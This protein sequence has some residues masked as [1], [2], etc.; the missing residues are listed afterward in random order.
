[1]GIHRHLPWRGTGGAE[2]LEKTLGCPAA[3][4]CF[5]GLTSFLKGN[6]VIYQ[7][8]KPF[9][10][11]T[12]SF[13]STDWRAVVGSEMSIIEW[14]LNRLKENTVERKPQHLHWKVK[15]THWRPE[16]QV[17]TRSESPRDLWGPVQVSPPAWRLCC[18]L[19][20]CYFRT[21]I[22]STH[23]PLGPWV[24]LSCT[25]FSLCIHTAYLPLPDL[26]YGYV[27]SASCWRII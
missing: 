27:S 26:C 13:N 25:F 21:Y 15:Q 12:V 18:F 17:E 4:V 1:M 14:H 3:S 16:T 10:K 2:I 22:T 11:I 24:S 20:R 8:W 5:C 7:C 9:R 6:E 19:N 23:S